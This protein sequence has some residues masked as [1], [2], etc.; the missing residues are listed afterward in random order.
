MEDEE[1]EAQRSSMTWPRS[2]SEWHILGR[3]SDTL[4]FPA[5]S[6]SVQTD[7]GSHPI[8]ELYLYKDNGFSIL[9]IA[10]EA[11]LI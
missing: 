9:W 5:C 3:V 1:T 2:Q 6:L 10:L 4:Y 11:C 8:P 7:W